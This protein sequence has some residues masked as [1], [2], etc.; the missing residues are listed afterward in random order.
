MRLAAAYASGVNLR[1]SSRIAAVLVLLTLVTPGC[2]DEPIFWIDSCFDLEDGSGVADVYL[3]GGYERYVAESA[4]VFIDGIAIQPYNE[5]IEGNKL[6]LIFRT[7]EFSHTGTAPAWVTFEYGRR[8][9][10]TARTNRGGDPV[11][12]TIVQIPQV[13]SI[14]PT[15][16]SVCGGDVVTITGTGFNEDSKVTVTGYASGVATEV[17]FFNDGFEISSTRITGTVANHEPYGSGYVTVQVDNSIDECFAKRTAPYQYIQDECATIETNITLA[18]GIALPALVA[19]GD[20]DSDNHN[21]VVVG[22]NGDNRI[23]VF[24]GDGGGEFPSRLTVELD[25]ADTPNALC[26]GDFNGDG[27]D[28]IAV[29]AA[30]KRMVRVLQESPGVLTKQPDALALPAAPGGIL[31]GEMSSDAKDDV[32]VMMPSYSRLIFTTDGLTG[33]EIPPTGLS[34]PDPVAMVAGTMPGSTRTGIFVSSVDNL[35]NGALDFAENN[36]TGDGLVWTSVSIA[37]PASGG[38]LYIP[39]A[40]SLAEWTGD[41]NEELILASASRDVLVTMSYTH[42]GTLIANPELATGRYLNL[43]STGSFYATHIAKQLAATTGTDA[44]SEV[45]VIDAAGRAHYSFTLDAT[46]HSIAVGKLD[47]DGFD[48]IVTGLETGLVPVLPSSKF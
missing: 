38:L 14:D 11:F 37:L 32:V 45:H 26:V 9:T 33:A 25:A 8:R 30:S 44:A 24:L 41:S 16:G 31:T 5:V 28:D 39:T 20:M 7:P 42:G 43:I 27:R 3:S 19:V 6:V 15:S 1:I 22:F 10:A 35:G 17:P 29:A 23:V 47:G 21:D 13:T 2:K 34:L 36:S 12:V 48:D 4:T 46:A 40:M 18:A